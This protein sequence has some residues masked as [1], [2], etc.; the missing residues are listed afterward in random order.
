MEGSN[1]TITGVADGTAVVTITARDPDG[2][3]AAQG[4]SVTVG[5]GNATNSAPQAVG[6]LA[7]REISVGGTSTVNV[8]GKFSDPDGDELTYGAES[9]NAEVATVAMDGVVATISGVAEGSAVVTITARDPDGLAA[10]QEVGV[11]VNAPSENSPPAAR[12]TIPDYNV[13]VGASTTVEVAGYF[14]DPDGDE[15]TYAATSSDEGVATIA[16]EGSTLTITGVADG[17]A[18]VNVTASD[19]S[20]G[21]AAQGFQVAVG[22]GA[23]ATEATVTIFGLRQTEDRNTSVNPSDVWGDIT[24]ILDV[25][26]NDET[27]AVIDLMLGEQ[28]INCRGVSASREAQAEAFGETE[29]EC[30]LNTAAVMGE[31][32]GTQLAPLYANGDYQLGARLTTSEGD[33]RETF[34]TQ[35]VTLNNSGFV[36]V[37]HSAGNSVLKSGVAIYGGPSDADNQNTFHACPV[38]Y[39]GT[40]VAKLSLRALNTDPAMAEPHEAATS[41]AFTAPTG[42]GAARKTFNGAAADREDTFSWEVHSSFNGAVQ[43]E[44]P[45]GREHWVFVGET[46]ENADGL[47]VRSDFGA[48][49]A[50]PTGPFYFDFR[51]PTAGG[52]RCGPGPFSGNSDRRRPA[53]VSLSA[54]NF[55]LDAS[56]G[57]GIGLGSHSISVGDCAANSSVNFPGRG[58]VNRTTVGFDALYTDVTSVA[59]LAE[60]DAVRNRD[61]NGAD[62]YVAELASLT[63]KLGNAWRSSGDPRLA[64]SYHHTATFGVDKTAPVLEDFEPDGFDEPTKGETVPGRFPQIVGPRRLP[65]RT[66]S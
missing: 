43:D 35:S 21:A 62:C 58:S 57:E 26:Q 5:R 39:G 7:A 34:A 4:V 42:T 41:L 2:A 44:G 19:P 37:T 47:D 11:S 27:I 9:S 8:T 6:S 15:L 65:R 64:S 54:G 49:D 20:G 51:A 63:D 22:R 23:P 31:C 45:G 10:A 17:T 60:D 66:A 53:G 38:S 24:V 25:Q 30:R 55:Y 16:A 40:E 14:S 12:G 28:V 13:A 18:T 29:I 56:D 48:A 36:M 50:E 46:M 61:S 33:E 52:D 1:A 32:T 3:A 59:E